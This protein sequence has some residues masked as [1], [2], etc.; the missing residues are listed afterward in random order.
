MVRVQAHQLPLLGPQ[1]AGPLPDAGRHGDPAEVVQQPG[2]VDEPSHRP[3]EAAR[4]RRA[5]AAATPREWP[6]N[7]GLFRSAAS[8]NPASASSRAASSRNVRRGSRLGV[9]DGRPQVVRARDRQQ[10][11]RRVREDRGD[12]R[13]E[14]AARP[15]GHRL[16]RDVG[17][18][19]GVEHDRR[20]ADRR[21]PRRLGDLL[22][23]PARP[24]RRDRRS[25]RSVQ[26]GPA[27]GLRQPQPAGQVG[28]DLAVRARPLGHQ[29]ADAGRRRPASAAASAPSPRPGQEPQRL[30]RLGRV[31]QV[32]AGA[33]DD[34]V[35]A[36]RGGDLV[37]RRGAAGEAQQRR[38]VDLALADVRRA[39]LAAP[40]RSP[41]GTRA[42]PRPAGARE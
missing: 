25:V 26:D 40:A 17:A 14:R 31:D 16:G 41:A 12:R 28:A 30:A 9:D 29:P 4:P 23:G 2:A 18:A 3:A 21:E 33:D 13:V 37:R 15:A 27:H 8:P 32:T 24:G 11:G 20:E 7:H 39:R 36:E 42:S 5:P 34:V 6:W 19:D 38:V 10:L 1:R 35:A 22:A